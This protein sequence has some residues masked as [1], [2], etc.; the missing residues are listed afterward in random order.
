VRT[1]QTFE[2]AARK[3]GMTAMWSGSVRPSP[4]LYVWPQTAWT[5]DNIDTLLFLYSVIFVHKLDIVR[6]EYVIWLQIYSAAL[7]PNIKI[8]HIW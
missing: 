8:G 7:L 5:D 4:A 1:E 3:T 2:K 6:K